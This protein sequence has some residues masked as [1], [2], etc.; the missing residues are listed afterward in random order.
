[1]G[2]HGGGH[3]ET[4]GTHWPWT[5]RGPSSVEQDRSVALL[6]WCTLTFIFWYIILYSDSNAWWIIS[7][8]TSPTAP[9]FECGRR[10]CTGVYTA[11]YYYSPFLGTVILQNNYTLDKYLGTI[12]DWW[13]CCEWRR[14]TWRALQ[15]CHYYWVGRHFNCL[16]RVCNNYSLESKVGIFLV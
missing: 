12:W 14:E 2:T 3:G 8:S 9:A 15:V 1:M 11:L 13:D 4:Q 5:E 7:R 10:T 16:N 6:L